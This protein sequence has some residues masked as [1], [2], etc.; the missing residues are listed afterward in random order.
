MLLMN[1]RKME[2][3]HFPAQK[4]LPNCQE[5]SRGCVLSQVDNIHVK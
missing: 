3:T 2:Y 5:N 1:D 4:A